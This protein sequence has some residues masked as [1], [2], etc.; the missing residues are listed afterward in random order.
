M[1]PTS[2]A[3]R[4]GSHVAAPPVSHA[5]LLLRLQS[6]LALAEAWRLHAE[7]L[8]RGHRHGT[9]LALQLVHVYAKLGEIGHALHAFDEMH[10]RNS[11]A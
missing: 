4:R 7:L 9:I 2:T 8:V 10:A 6:G 5:W 1:P 3:S 11:F